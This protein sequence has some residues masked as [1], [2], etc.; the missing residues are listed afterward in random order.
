MN[1][2]MR[3]QSRLRQ[4]GAPPGTAF[5]ERSRCSICVNCAHVA[6]A[7]RGTV[8]PARWSICAFA[9]KPSGD[10]SFGKP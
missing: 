5:D 10:Q 9:I 8:T 7:P 1:G 2:R 3:A 4:A 6:G